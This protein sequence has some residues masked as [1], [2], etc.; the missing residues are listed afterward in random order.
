MKKYYSFLL[1]LLIIYA[2]VNINRTFASNSVHT[3][4][5]VPP[6]CVSYLPLIEKYDWNVQTAINVMWAESGCNPDA[7]NLNDKHKSRIYPRDYPAGFCVGSFGLFQ[8]SCT[9]PIYY[10]A[11][12]N[13]KQAYE[14]YQEQGWS[15]WWTTC[16]TKVKCNL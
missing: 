9:R 2:S 11:P 10:D 13:I 14:I 6:A 15:A 12:Q 16:H 7:V 1:V 8:E 5:V 3:D 4:F